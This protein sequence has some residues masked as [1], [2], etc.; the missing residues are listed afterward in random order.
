MSKPTKYTPDTTKRL[1]DA[2]RS[3][4]TV[5]AACTMAGVTDITL[6]RW[7]RQH[8]DLD[9]AFKKAT[10]EQTWY[11]RKAVRRAGFRTYERKPDKHLS[12]QEKALRGQINGSGGQDKQGEMVMYEGLPVR[13]GNI[14]EDKPYLPCVNPM[15]GRVEYLKRENGRNVQHICDIEVFKR[16]F[17]GWY[18]KIR[19]T[20]SESFYPCL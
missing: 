20:F 11:S 9:A 4:F 16:S 12:N 18:R 3:G 19:N 6:S 7:R 17:P 10:K 1:L 14:T 15:S 8:S 5:K 2:I 13:F